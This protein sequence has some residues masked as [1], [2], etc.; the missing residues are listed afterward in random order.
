MTGDYLPPEQWYAQ[1]PSAYVAACAFF[2]D[3][4]GHVLLVKPNYRDRWLFPGGHAEEDEFPHVACA[5]EVREELGL[6]VPIGDLLV[7][8]WSPSA[9]PRPRPMVTW[10]FDGGVLDAAR[11]PEIRLQEDELDAS[12]FFEPKEA[13]DLLGYTGVRVAAAFEARATGR[14]VYVT[15]DEVYRGGA[16]S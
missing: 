15:H 14:T 8:H 4:R 10:V 6:D 3:E 7:V 13:A 2:T 11:S 16:P 9:P 1:L 12:A 5:R